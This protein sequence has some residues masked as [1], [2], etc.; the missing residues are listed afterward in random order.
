MSDPR[1]TIHDF[2]A[3]GDNATSASRMEMGRALVSALRSNANWVTPTRNRDES[4]FRTCL[5]PFGKGFVYQLSQVVHHRLYQYDPKPP[6]IDSG[7]RRPGI[8]SL[9]EWGF[10]PSPDS[11]ECTSLRHLD[12]FKS[13]DF[14]VVT[15][16]SVG[17][18]EPARNGSPEAPLLQRGVK[19]MLESDPIFEPVKRPKLIISS[20]VNLIPQVSGALRC[21]RRTQ[22]VL[23]TFSPISWACA[24]P[25]SRTLTRI[26]FRYSPR[27]DHYLF[28]LITPHLFRN[29]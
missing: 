23:H 18:R 13:A 15:R 10:L 29:F 4:A 16:C 24:M 3:D 9:R 12:E 21:L 7:I 8:G 22:F 6:R 17:S 27:G 14:E 11:D 25:N 20:I 26:D 1:T 28:H 5:F 2:V 19:R